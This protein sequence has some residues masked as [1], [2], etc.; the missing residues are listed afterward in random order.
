[1]NDTRTL[2]DLKTI[3]IMM[4]NENVVSYAWQT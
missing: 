2:A 4:Y 3:G 1:M